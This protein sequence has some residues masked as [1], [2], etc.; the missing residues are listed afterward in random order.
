MNT[1]TVR[2]L[3]LPGEPLDPATV[4]A[5]DGGLGNAVTWAVSLRP[6]PPA[7]PRLRG[8]ELALVSTEYMA[9]LDPPLT[10][11]EVVR[12]LASR[13]AAGVAVRGQVDAGA[14]AEARRCGL[15]LLKLHADLPLP[16]IEQ[17]IMRECALH[18]VRRE[19]QPAQEPDSWLDD[20]LA[21]RLSAGEAQQ[22]ARRQGKRVAPAYSVAFLLPPGGHLADDDP[23]LAGLV[24]AI[25]VRSQPYGAFR[26]HHEDGLVLLLP[27][28]ADSL[29]WSSLLAS[30]SIP[31]GVGTESPLAGASESLA[32][33]RQA[34]IASALLWGCLPVRYGEM[35]ADR[36]LVTI[37]RERPDE[38]RRFVEDTLGP[39]LRHDAGSPAPLLPTLS[40]FVTHGGRLRETASDIFVHRNTL[41]YRLDRAAE[42]LGAD[43][44]D[45]RVRL[46]LELALRALPLVRAL[47]GKGE[48]DGSG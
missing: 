48:P 17:A 5:G 40:A 12:H 3:L 14:V 18:Q 22:Y 42:V 4:L 45:P 24:G 27:A 28:Q 21:G 43:I 29:A 47:D 8:G 13:D 46:S 41:A 7:F 25:E 36:L 19:M 34:A 37:Y 11:E 9:R 33:A 1:L 31:C 44:K 32:E 35:G 15:P 2:D 38:L 30:L 10:L 39:L 16:D 20:L 6:F 26:R 23:R